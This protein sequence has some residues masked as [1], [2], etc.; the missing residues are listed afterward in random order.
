MHIL[1]FNLKSNIVEVSGFEPLTIAVQRRRSTNWAI[2][3]LGHSGFEPETSPLSGARSNQ[4][5]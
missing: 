5:S 3:P 4:L 1:Y 2:P